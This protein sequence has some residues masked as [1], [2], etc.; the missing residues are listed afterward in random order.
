MPEELRLTEIDDGNRADHARLT[1]GDKC[2]FLFEYTSGQKW[3]FSATNGLIS[4]LKRKPGQKGKYYKDQEIG[5]VGRYFRT[6][7]ADDWLTNAT[8]V[9]IPPSKAVGHEHYDPRMERICKAIKPG[10]DVRCL[11]RQKTSTTAA[12]ELA[13]KPRPSIA[14]LLD[15]YE[16]D[17]NLCVPTPVSIG[18]F[19]DVLTAGT[20]FKAV[21]SILTDRFP[22]VPIFGI[23]I[24]RR[25]F[26]EKSGEDWF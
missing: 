21:Q 23:F 5:K 1:E 22:D 9:P 8:L 6:T 17:K 4:T 15:N 14:D 26:P 10:L 11:V 12:H 13:G 20:H 19:D 16:I 18:V 3:N 25:V 2:L 7:L 24:A